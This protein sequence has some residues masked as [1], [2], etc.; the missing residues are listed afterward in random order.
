[1]ISLQRRS[2]TRTVVFLY[3]VLDATAID[4]QLGKSLILRQDLNIRAIL[5]N[6]LKSF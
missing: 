1:M 4:E 3:S 2:S 6:S 5:K